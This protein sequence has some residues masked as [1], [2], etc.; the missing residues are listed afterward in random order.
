MITRKSYPGGVA[1]ERPDRR[2]GQMLIFVSLSLLVLVSITGFAVDLGYSY[3]IKI[4]A[5]GAA[6]SAASAAAI[7][8]NTNGYACVGRAA[9]TCANST[10]SCPSSVTSVGT[11]LQAGCAYA[12]VN[13]F[14]NTGNQSV[15]LIANTPAAAAVPNETGNSPA[16]WIQAN[17]SQTVPHWF[18]YWAGFQSQF[19]GGAGNQWR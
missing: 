11:A 13:G 14:T 19:G 5:Q 6:D 12:G 9:L 8:A 17:V 18:L 1:S 7:Y 4:Y 2:S 15:S 10:Y 3:Y 16:L